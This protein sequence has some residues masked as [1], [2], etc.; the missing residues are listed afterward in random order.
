MHRS[1]RTLIA[2]AV[3][4]L[5][6]LTCAPQAQAQPLNGVFTY[7]GRLNDGTSPANGDYTIR[8]RLFDAA[9]GGNQ[10]GATAQQIVT[11]E[12]GLF[13]IQVATGD[14]PTVF[15]GQRLWLELSVD[16]FPLS[17][18]F[19]TLSPRQELTATPHANYA[20]TSGTSLQDAYANGRTIDATI[21]EPVEMSGRFLFRDVVEPTDLFVSIREN[22]ANDFS[23]ID[24]FPDG[25]TI[26]TADGPNIT[27]R[28]PD[29]TLLFTINGDSNG[30]GVFFV[31]EGG[32]DSSL[33][34]DGSFSSSGGGVLSIFGLT[35]SSS[36]NT[37]Q[38]GDAAVSLPVNAINATETAEEAGLANRFQNAPGTALTSTNTS[39]FQRT[40]TA[41]TD[42]YVV[43]ISTTELFINHT[44]GNDTIVRL[45]LAT[46][47]GTFLRG[48]EY[49]YKIDASV[50]SD[51]SMS[52]TVTIHAT[53]PV[54]AGS[55]TIHLNSQLIG[56]NAGTTL[57][58]YELTTLFVPT[59]YGS[60]G[61]GGTLRN[62]GVIED[63]VAVS[64]IATLP[65]T[66]AEMQLEREASELENDRRV[67]AELDAMRREL[68]ELRRRIENDPD[69]RPRA[70][71]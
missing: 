38:P 67:L 27:L 47:P 23:L 66:L 17:G 20:V 25:A 22:F 44:T 70:H 7:Q 43:A 51:S 6:L 65:P 61:G 62:A 50:G 33:T 63:E 49:D 71:D 14:I 31:A 36:F 18:R 39:L 21:A 41:P 34:W 3:A 11:A 13:T 28:Q 64:A 35:S 30:D 24:V 48:L 60:I 9:V 56:S 69:A 10:V 57:G 46:A 42:G 4:A 2:Q 29:E 45:G 40:I 12:D 68:D 55:R 59:A 5:A 54:L 16:S 52:R 58:D 26:G 32:D 53:F 1:A 8:W 37:N 19:T 15:T